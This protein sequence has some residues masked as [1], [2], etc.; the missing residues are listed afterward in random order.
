MAYNEYYLSLFRCFPNLISN[1]LSKSRWTFIR[2]YSQKPAGPR[3]WRWHLEERR[4]RLA[5]HA[6]FY[7][8]ADELAALLR[9]RNCSVLHSGPTAGDPELAWLLCQR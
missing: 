1:P 2:N 4:V 3:S 6:T 8:S 5:G 9:R 7:R